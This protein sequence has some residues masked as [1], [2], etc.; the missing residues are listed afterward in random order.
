MVSDLTNLGYRLVNSGEDTDLTAFFEGGIWGQRNLYLLEENENGRSEEYKPYSETLGEGQ[1]SFWYKT[2]MPGTLYVA[3]GKV[4]VLGLQVNDIYEQGLRLPPDAEVSLFPTDRKEITN[5]YWTVADVVDVLGMPSGYNLVTD[6][7]IEGAVCAVQFGY[8]YG[9]MLIYVNFNPA[10]Y[11]TSNFES[12]TVQNVEYYNLE[13][14]E[15]AASTS[16][17]DR[18]IRMVTEE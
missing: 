10:G 15:E 6:E 8:D 5:T 14:I 11:C 4:T 3:E 2:Y 13:L 16:F 7:S 12:L 9:D 17:D 18:H 1:I